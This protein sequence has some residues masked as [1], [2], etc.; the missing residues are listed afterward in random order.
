MKVYEVTESLTNG[1]TAGVEGIVGIGVEFRVRGVV[2][3]GE[4]VGAEVTG[5]LSEFGPLTAG[6]FC[7]GELGLDDRLGEEVGLGDG[8]DG[9]C[10]EGEG[11]GVA[12][13]VGVGSGVDSGADAGATST[14]CQGLTVCN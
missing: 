8:V 6:W 14:C 10:V 4:F 13:T 1:L 3:E 11:C 2:G 12:E 9:G 5:E 7:D